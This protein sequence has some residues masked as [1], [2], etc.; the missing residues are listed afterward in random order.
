MSQVSQDHEIYVVLLKKY[1]KVFG[2]F[3][4]LSIYIS[5]WFGDLLW[6]Q[7][8]TAVSNL[9]ITIRVRNFLI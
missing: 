4:S 8:Q 5:L 1:T 2:V 9:C 3:L 6:K 7:I